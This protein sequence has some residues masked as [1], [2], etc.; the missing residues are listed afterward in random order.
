MLRAMDAA[1]HHER[2]IP[3]PGCWVQ[4]P[5]GRQGL[6]VETRKERGGVLARF[7]YGAQRQT[8][9]D[10][11][12]LRSAFSP[13]MQVE[14]RPAGRAADSQGIGEV[15]AVRGIA[16]CEQVLVQFHESGVARWLPFQTLGRIKPVEDRL[17]GGEVGPFG[18]HAERF[19][20][21]VLAHAL[22]AWDWST[23]A[24]GRLDLDPLPHQIHLA[25]KVLT[26]GNVNWLIAD[27]VGLGKTIEVGLILHGLARRN[28]AR[29]VLII[30]PAGLVRQWQDEMRFK[31]DQLY[32]IYGRDFQVRDPVHWRLH[33][34]VIVSLD[35]AKRE[36]QRDLLRAAG[37]WD[38]V[39]FDEAHRLGRSETGERTDRYRLAEALR[40]LTPALLLLSGTPH[41]GKT[42]RFTAL[43]EL[44]RPNLKDELR[45]L[46]ADPE[47]VAGVVLR[48]R[49]TKVTDAQGKPLFNGHETHRIAVA[50]SPATTAFVA[51][52]THYLRHGY[53]VGTRAGSGGRAIGFVMTTY[54]KLAS[55]SIAAICRALELRCRR[56]RAARNDAAPDV[57]ALMERIEEVGDELAEQTDLFGGRPFFAGEVE[58]IERL[59]RLAAPVR[60]ADEK[61]ALFIEQ[62]ARPLHEKGRKLLV[63]TEYR[64]TQTYL[65]EALRQA[66][67]EAGEPALIHGSMS[68]D[69]KLANIRRFR[70]EAGFLISTEAGGEGLN[71]HEGCHVLANYDLPWN[72]SRLVQRIGRLYRYGQKERVV[73]FNLHARDSFDNAALGLML[74]RVEAI[75]RDLAPISD[76]FRESLEAEILGELLENIDMNAILERATELRLELSEAEIDAA[77]R[78]AQEALRLQEE[79]L[80]FATGYD[81]AARS[82]VFG[83]DGRHLGTFVAGM[84]PRIGAG[85]VRWLHD[86]RAVRF[87]LPESLAGAFPEF[88]R[89]RTVTLALD[90]RLARDREDVFPVDFDSPF[91]R[92][93]IAEAKSRAFDGLYSAAAGLP[94]A[95]LAVY[96][97]RWQDDRGNPLED[98]LVC[99]GADRD[100]EAAERL[101]PARFGELLLRP[102]E[103]GQPARREDRPQR[104]AEL[105]QAFEAEAGR[106]VAR[107]RQPGSML[108]LAAAEGG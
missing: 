64:A 37:S 74:E 48:N 101:P 3:A 106:G 80:S 40:P 49:K 12:Q 92:H 93:L 83:I 22:E 54:R 56:L 57:A 6:V 61:L 16:G 72:P 102:L 53:A 97:L 24:L 32:E 94:L 17:L 85:N 35:L 107:S 90:R 10:A 81:A 46:E 77:I 75:A 108:L 39:V 9:I 67:P 104:L 33:E 68:L 30:C 78:Q 29:R 91:F 71:L 103:S 8:W 87:E 55:S 58:Q 28:Q 63:F 19:R 84:L 50:P 66:L 98:E 95:W 27:D 99:V 11:F 60:A 47:L 69:E 73:V 59:L 23:G 76:E 82:G 41:Q 52:L 86:G 79:M 1:M 4:D 45:T 62:V 25:H 36:D 42:A 96:F 18:D 100:G 105:R 88:G 31:F 15:Q 13:G 7:R 51:E 2:L 34:K 43:L 26:S 89:R 38:V 20:L 44:V 65:Q 5:A 21:R 14:H 70:D